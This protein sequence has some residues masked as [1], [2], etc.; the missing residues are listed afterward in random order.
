MPSGMEN[1]KKVKNFFI[2]LKIEKSE[3]DRTPIITCGSDIVCVGTLRTD[4]R[5]TCG[6]NAVY[7]KIF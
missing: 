7:L 3:R 5:Y 6:D 1:F 4:N 2:D